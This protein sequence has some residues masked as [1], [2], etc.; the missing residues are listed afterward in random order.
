MGLSG[1]TPGIT[2]CIFF[3]TATFCITTW[4]KLTEM[5][6]DKKVVWTYDSAKMNGNEGKRVDVHAFARLKNGNTSIVESGVGRI[7]RS[8]KRV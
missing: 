3:P 7:V 2:M 8:T 4:T 6:L 5:T 1:V